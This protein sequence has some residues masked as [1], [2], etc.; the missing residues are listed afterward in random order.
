[1]ATPYNNGKKEA[2]HDSNSRPSSRDEEFGEV[3]HAGRGNQLVKSLKNRHLQMIA[4]GGAIGAG[5]FVGSGRA[6]A[7]GGP[8]SLIICYSIVGIMILNTCQALAE[9]AVLYPINGAFYQYVIR[10]VDPSWG[11]AIGWSYALTWLTVLPFELVVVAMTIDYWDSPVPHGVWIAV[12]LVILSAIQI[13]GVKGYGEVECALSMIKIIACLGFMILG[14]IINCGG[15]GPQGY[16]GA[17]YWREPG[18]FTGGFDG[19]CSVFVVAAFSFGGTEL[20]GLAAAESQNPQKSIPQAS[21]QVFVRIIFFYIINLFILGLIL[22]FDH[23]RL[24]G[25][26]SRSSPFV[27]AISEAGIKVLPDIMNAII[28]IAVISVANCCA[29]GSTR[30]IQAM[31]SQG[32]APKFFHKIDSKG[33]PVNCIILQLIF[34]LLAFIGL[35]PSGKKIFDWLLA[36]TALSY[37]FIWGSVCLAHIRF[38]KAMHLQGIS[39]DV[40]PYTPTLGVYGSYCGLGLIFLSLLATFYSA[41]APAAKQKEGYGIDHFFAEYLA[42]FVVLALYLFWKIYTKQWRLCIPLHEIDLQTGAK[43]CDPADKEVKEKSWRTLPS[44]IFGLFI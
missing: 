31:A 3:A 12:F 35:A 6:L 39:L 26:T 42:G 19:F 34:G 17:K 36:L 11:F 23:E 41:V 22:P 27:I 25:S 30:T 1:M 21:R 40:V 28:V 4:M 33:R 32:M 15:V 14:I 7:S 44:R 8:A 24:G 9:M 20:V 13:F 18:A 10:F 2:V 5:L 29:Y 43:F 16:L 38:R 37:F